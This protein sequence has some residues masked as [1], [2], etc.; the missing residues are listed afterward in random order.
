MR[1]FKAMLKSRKGLDFWDIF[2]YMFYFLVAFIIIFLLNIAGCVI[3]DKE[4]KAG[5][6]ADVSL[7]AVIRADAQLDSYLRTQMPG[8]GELLEKMGWLEKNKNA[9]YIKSLV[10]ELNFDFGKVEDFLNKHPEV[11]A[12]R[13]YS[14]FI[15]SLHPFYVSGDKKDKED[16]ERVFKAVTAAMFIR[17]VIDYPKK[18]D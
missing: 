17:A 13:D 7:A 3:K 1:M 4:A 12:D 6:G 16:A 8:K 9:N 18:G 5:I 2:W 14:G 11:Y 10:K 15:S